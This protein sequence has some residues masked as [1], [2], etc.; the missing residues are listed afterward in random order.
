M[1]VGRD[2]DFQKKPDMRAYAVSGE[3]A[4]WG[5]GATWGANSSNPT[6][7]GSTRLVDRASPMS[8][9]GKYTQY[10]F[11]KKGVDTPIELYGYIA[12]YKAGRAR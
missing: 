5:G 3:G 1:W 12:I 8:G 7:W 10:R 2:I 9:R 6:I 4:T 11:E